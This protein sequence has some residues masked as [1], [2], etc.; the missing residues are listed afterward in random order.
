MLRLT[1]AQGRFVHLSSFSKAEPQLSPSWLTAWCLA[2][3]W[4]K[5]YSHLGEC[6]TLG[7]RTPQSVHT[8]GNSTWDQS[9]A[10]AGHIGT[11]LSGLTAPILNGPLSDSQRPRWLPLHLLSWLRICAKLCNVFNSLVEETIWK[12]YNFFFKCCLQEV[13]IKSCQ[14]C[15]TFPSIY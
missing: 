6:R 15:H 10:F 14:I 9:A 3:F 8:R 5:I 4:M 1:G 11:S 2:L 13:V 12:G 7:L